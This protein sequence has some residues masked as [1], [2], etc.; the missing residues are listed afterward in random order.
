M[1]LVC[2]ET[3]GQEEHLTVDKIYFSNSVRDNSYNVCTD[4]GQ[5]LWLSIDRFKISKGH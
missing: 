4:T 3:F 2:V 1:F 5:W